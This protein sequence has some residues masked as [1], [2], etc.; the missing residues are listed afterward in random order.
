MADGQTWTEE[1]TARVERQ[2]PIIQGELVIKARK[3]QVIIKRFVG[4]DTAWI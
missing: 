3:G 2:C 4:V 1:E